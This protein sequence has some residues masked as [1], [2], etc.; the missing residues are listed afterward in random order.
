[1]KVYLARHGRA[2]SSNRDSS[3]P[4]SVEGREDIAML[5]RTLGN[6]NVKVNRIYH[7]GKLRA[8]ETARIIAETLQ[9]PGGVEM[10]P[11]LEPN[12]DV[13]PVRQMLN[14]AEDDLMLVGHLPFMA[15][16]LQLL[17][18]QPDQDELPFFDTGNVVAVEKIGNRW[19]VFR[20]LGP[21]MIL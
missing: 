1:M 10:M 4:L 3:Q 5:S 17:L 11:G 19:Q 18:E 8:E 15:N 6:M 21:R 7:S 20:H 12:D 13:A 14:R 9:P 2:L 16:L